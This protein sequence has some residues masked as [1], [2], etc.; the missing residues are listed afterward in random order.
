MRDHDDGPPFAV[1]LEQ[2]AQNPRRSRCPMRQSARPQGA[3]RDWRRCPR[4]RRAL[5][6]AARKQ[7][8]KMMDTMGELHALYGLQARRRRSARRTPA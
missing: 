2:D 1:E 4:D 3:R 5:L 7:R 6:F 8:R